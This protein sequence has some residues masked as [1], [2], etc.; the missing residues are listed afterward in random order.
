MLADANLRMML[1]ICGGAEPCSVHETRLAGFPAV[2][3]R[4]GGQGFLFVRKNE[5]W[6]TDVLGRILASDPPPAAHYYVQPSTRSR[7][8]RAE[9]PAGRT[10]HLPEGGGSGTAQRGLGLGRDRQ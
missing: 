1:E 6:P 10:L 5:Q 8:D 4:R 2:S 7:Y 3:V 9:P